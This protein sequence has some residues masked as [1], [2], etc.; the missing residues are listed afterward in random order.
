[1]EL[2]DR[3]LHAVR[4]WLPKSQQE[5][6][7]AELRED[8][9]SQIEDREAQL[10]RPLDED[11]LADLLEQRGNPIL[12][13]AGYS[14]RRSL[15][16]PTLFPVYR[17]VLQLVI[18]WI[19]LPIFILVVGP[20]TILSSRNSPGAIGETVWTMLMAAVFAFGVITLI[21]AI[22]ERYPAESILKWNPRRL[23]RVPPAKALTQLKPVTGYA[24]IAE[25]LASTAA[26]LVWIGVIWLRTSFDFNG[27]VITPAPVWHRLFWP[28]LL[29]TLSGIPAGLIGWLSPWRM[30]ARAYV[31]LAAD[32]LTL[33]LTAALANMGPWVR[34]TAANLPAADL[35]DAN[36][37]TNVGFSIGFAFITIVTLMDAGMEVRRLFRS[38]TASGAA[39][40][41]AVRR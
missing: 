11:A 3:Y 28:I 6:I 8:L 16:G 32:A 15:I 4:F 2:L 41:V 19:L 33:I 20:A 5:D 13:A 9:H 37:W 21:F 24:A 30:R 31:R 14:P 25:L 27:V 1:M 38:E 22:M 36:H 17:F 23:P 7:I 35:S 12:V 29:V 26:G 18:L 40:P 39:T 10:G 34:V